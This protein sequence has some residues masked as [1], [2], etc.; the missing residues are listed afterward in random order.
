MN[1]ISGDKIKKL[2]IFGQINDFLSKLSTQIEQ[3]PRYI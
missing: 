2:Q 1:I 3:H